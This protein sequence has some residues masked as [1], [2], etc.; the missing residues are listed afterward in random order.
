M[1]LSSDPLS[2]VSGSSLV[3]EKM[4]VGRED[5]TKSDQPDFMWKLVIEN[6]DGYFIPIT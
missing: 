1:T 5:H 4:M 6:T 3:D 2:N